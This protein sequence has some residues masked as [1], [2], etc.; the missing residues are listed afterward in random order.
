MPA[1]IIFCLALLLIGWLIGQPW[2]TE[3]RRQRIRARPFP[4]A[5]RD[6]LKRRVP[7]VR[8][9]PA[10]LQLQ[11]KQLIQVFLA[12]KAFIGCDG[13]EIT[14]EIRV[15]IAAQACLLILN[16]PRDYYP[17]LRQILVYPDSF[18]VQRGHTDPAGVA[19]EG[20]QVL[21]GESWA[22]GQVILS[23]HDTLT[24]AATPDDGQNVVIHEFAHQLDQETGS[25]NGA[26][27]LARRA[28]YA[29]WSEVLGTE[30]RKLQARASRYRFEHDGESEPSLFSDYGATDP[31]EFFA[32]ISE[33]F[34]EQPHRMASEHPALYRELS[35][36][37][38]LDPLSW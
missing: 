22:D 31:A 21:A 34:F 37:Y 10:D 14:D 35:G 6:I 28:H 32:V 1:F 8:A 18:V 25:A 19:H 3:R 24:G 12:E 17:G 29:R 16:R 33:V 4:A 15:T 11:L 38:R 13:L 7:Y 20:R 26:P 9:L 30:F 2:L 23:W 27:I 5:W 36:F